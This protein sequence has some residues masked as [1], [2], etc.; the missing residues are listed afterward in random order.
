VYT[1]YNNIQKFIQFQLTINVAS[2]VINFVAAVSS[3]KVPLT[4]IQL[5][6]VN[7]IMD[8]LAA[9]ALATKKPINDIMVRHHGGQ[10]EP[11][12]TR[13]MW[14]NLLAQALYQVTVLLILQFKGR[15]IFGVDESEENPQ[16]QYFCPLLSFQ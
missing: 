5:L 2:L 6:W 1:L 7:L 15:Y 14:R 4:T 9:L 11:F 13:V 12:I 16:F 8:T 10:S 3:S